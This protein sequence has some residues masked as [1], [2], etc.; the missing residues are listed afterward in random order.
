MT[1]RDI[2]AAKT[3]AGYCDP[4]YTVC[5]GGCEFCVRLKRNYKC[6]TLNFIVSKDAV[7]RR[8]FTPRP[9]D[10]MLQMLYGGPSRSGQKGGGNG[11][12]EVQGSREEAREEAREEVTA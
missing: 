2:E 6:L 3:Q 8:F 7:C 9:A 5:C 11:S 10:S 12:Q 4:H 1:R